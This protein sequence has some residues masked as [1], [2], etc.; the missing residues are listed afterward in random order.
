MALYYSHRENMFIST[1]QCT[2]SERITNTI[3]KAS[4]CVDQKV[5]L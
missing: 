4:K 5:W 2:N 3:D 1:S